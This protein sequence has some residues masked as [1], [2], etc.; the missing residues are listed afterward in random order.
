MHSFVIKLL[1]IK[2]IIQYTVKGC[3]LN[4]LLDPRLK[5]GFCY[6]FICRNIKLLS[7]FDKCFADTLV[8]VLVLNNFI[9]CVNVMSAVYVVSL[10]SYLILPLLSLLMKVL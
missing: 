10:I 5:L 4:V 8:K 2:K 6:S 3:F 7:L 9:L 1:S